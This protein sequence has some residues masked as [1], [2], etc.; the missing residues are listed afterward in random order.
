MFSVVAKTITANQCFYYI[1]FQV[2][3]V[4]HDIFAATGFIESF[5]FHQNTNI[6]IWEPIVKNNRIPNQIIVADL[7]Y[8]K[9]MNTIDAKCCVIYSANRPTV[10][11]F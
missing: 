10:Y 4:E 3:F 5:I 2:I 11:N 9:Q 7:A 6:K 1:V 8:Y